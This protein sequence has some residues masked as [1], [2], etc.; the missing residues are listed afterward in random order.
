LVAAERAVDLTRTVGND[1]LLAEAQLW[2]GEA[3]HMLARPDE[4]L[5]ALEAAIVLAEAAGDLRI[6]TWAH[7]NASA[8]YEDRGEFAKSRQ[9]GER[10]LVVAERHGDPVQLALKTTRQGMSAFYAGDW[11]R[12][13]AY[14]ERAV[15]M[16]QRVGTSWVSM[17]CLLDLG[18]LCVAEG[19]WAE[20]AQCLEESLTL[21]ERF[22]DLYVIRATQ[23]ALAERDLLV[24]QAAA[25]HERLR[26][27]LDR[28]GLQ[29]ASVS[30]LL[31][32]LA[33]ALLDWDDVAGAAAIA[34]QA[35]ARTRREN[36]RL[37]LTDA[38]RVQAKV[39]TR[40]G[41]WSEAAQAL[42]EGLTLAR[43]MPCPYAEARLLHVY[44]HMHAQKGE[45][46]PARERFEAALAIFRRL[47]AC[48]HV[49]R[50]EQAIADLQQPVL[51][52]DL[53]PPGVR[54]QPRRVDDGHAAGPDWRCRMWQQPDPPL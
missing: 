18:R 48:K 42:E 6:L 11:G 3:L 37:H 54:S 14:F 23:C 46:G 36:M 28:P 31:S 32:R 4:A 9:Y 10:A 13:R 29:E 53:A 35:A 49:E 40:Q 20:A 30:V 19:A 1:R 16:C 12:A 33:W 45:P 25:A 8:I 34:A 24:G 26:A 51:D 43:S 2:H 47:G 39:A 50:V 27:L 5:G 44:G 15:A 17:Y 21:A 7:T 38:L 52:R 22:G 41:H